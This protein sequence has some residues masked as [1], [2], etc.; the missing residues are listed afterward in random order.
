MNGDN[1]KIKIA[2]SLFVILALGLGI[3]FYNNSTNK[4]MSTTNESTTEDVQIELNAKAINT[5]FKVFIN[6][7][8]MMNVEATNIS[9]TPNGGSIVLINEDSKTLSDPEVMKDKF[10]DLIRDTAVL[11][12]GENKLK[13]EY[14]S[15]NNADYS[16]ISIRIQEL[17]E[18]DVDTPEN[19]KVIYQNIEDNVREGTIEHTFS[20]P[21]TGEPIIIGPQE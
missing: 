21:F 7:R 20:L 17:K 15:L 11:K 18:I 16:G 8:E 5:I 4:I 19:K 1:K 10:Y 2:I 13:V 14:K 6:D 9:D 3:Y 12:K